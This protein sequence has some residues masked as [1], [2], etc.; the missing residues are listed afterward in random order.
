[1]KIESEKLARKF[2]LEED[3]GGMVRDLKSKS[4]FSRI[5]DFLR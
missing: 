4:F 2:V 5:K 3:W 1:M